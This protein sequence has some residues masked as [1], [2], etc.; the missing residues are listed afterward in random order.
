MKKIIM[1]LAAMMLVFGVS[2]QAMA[3][4]ADG[5]LIRVVYSSSGTVESATDLGSISAWTA[6]SPTNV[7]YNTN[8]FNL[9]T[10]G[11][12]ANASNSYVSYFSIM[13]APNPNKAWTSGDLSGTQGIS[14]SNW[15]VYVGAAHNANA[16]YALSGVP[17]A[18]LNMSDSNSFYAGM[19][20]SVPGSGTFHGFVPNGGGTVSLASLATTG[21]VDQK[22]YYY[23]GTPTR[24]TGTD[25]NILS[26]NI[27]VVRTYADGHTELNPTVPVPAAAYL[28]GSGLLGLVGIRRK[29]AA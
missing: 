13:A 24:G 10:L 19:D 29:N 25:S 20:A 22:L 7:V 8:N 15:S 28:F 2:G 23:P 4:F 21:Y 11:A 16:Q 5:D 18:T 6:P 27:P 3:Y 12:G 9:S 26:G 17:T 1:L 14:A